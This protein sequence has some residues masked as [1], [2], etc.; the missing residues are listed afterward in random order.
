VDTRI[1]DTIKNK[2]LLLSRYP[3]SEAAVD[4]FSIAERFCLEMNNE[5]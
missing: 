1:R 4:V 5:Q 3:T 2:E